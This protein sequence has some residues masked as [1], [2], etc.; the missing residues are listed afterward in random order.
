MSC[1]IVDLVLA[2]QPSGRFELE[3]VGRRCNNMK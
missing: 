3:L 1:N 2:D